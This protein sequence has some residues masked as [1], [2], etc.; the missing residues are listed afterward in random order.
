[1]ATR[2]FN[3]RD[4]DYVFAK[5]EAGGSMT[6]EEDP[7]ELGYVAP[8]V[9]SESPR[10]ILARAKAREATEEHCAKD[11]EELGDLDDE[12]VNKL[13]EEYVD[14]QRPCRSTNAFLRA[15][16]RSSTAPPEEESW[17]SARAEALSDLEAEKSFS[18]QCTDGNLKNQGQSMA[19]DLA[20]LHNKVENSSLSLVVTTIDQVPVLP[21]RRLACAKPVVVFAQKPQLLNP[22][23]PVTTTILQGPIQ[24]YRTV[25]SASPL[26]ALSSTAA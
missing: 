23:S 10:D 6:S 17:A 1:L 2:L 19:K 22:M 21:H 15:S 16:S 5:T 4:P 7:T 13:G 11:V 24:L 20:S 26:L 18:F 25:A 8:D 3:R 14:L 9:T 12:E